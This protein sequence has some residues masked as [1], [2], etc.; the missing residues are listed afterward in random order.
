[1]IALVVSAAVG[2]KQM[3]RKLVDYCGI[4]LYY[5]ST[6]LQSDRVIVDSSFP[7]PIN[8]AL[9]YATCTLEPETAVVH[10]QRTCQ[11]TPLM[12]RHT[13]YNFTNSGKVH[14]KEM[15]QVHLERPHW[16]SDRRPRYPNFWEPE[17]G[18]TFPGMLSI[19]L[20]GPVLC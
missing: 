10:L 20:V 9:V 8:E 19:T 11:Q 16:F 3:I 4:V 15:K 1:M 13:I 14:R 17:V 7:T 6:V 2:E 12:Q 5:S 18:P